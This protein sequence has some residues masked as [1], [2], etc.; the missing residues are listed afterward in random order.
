[1]PARTRPST[2]RSAAASTPPDANRPAPLVAMNPT[3]GPIMLHNDLP[4]PTS[5]RGRHVIELDIPGE[6]FVPPTQRRSLSDDEIQRAI[7]VAKRTGVFDPKLFVNI[8]DAL[9]EAEHAQVQ[10]AL[11]KLDDNAMVPELRG[12][13]YLRLDTT[14]LHPMPG[15]VSEGGNSDEVSG[16]ATGGVSGGVSGE[17]AIS[18]TRG[19]YAYTFSLTPYARPGCC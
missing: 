13:N 2:R 4:E 14:W 11:I 12:G 16:E 7:L 1:M 5:Y 15:S 18:E 8:P 10:Q 6:W 3:G 17:A 19:S 9:D